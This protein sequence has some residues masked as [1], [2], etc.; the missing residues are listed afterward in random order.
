M[1]VG[2]GVGEAGCSPPSHSLISDY[3]EPRRR[4]TALSIYAFG[5]P[6]GAMIGSVAGGWLAKTYGWRVAFMAVGRPGVIL[7]L[8]VKLLVK[9]PP[10]GHSDPVERPLVVADVA[11]HAVRAPILAGCGP[12]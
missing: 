7:A 12:R 2:V 3:F 8:L 11:P 5:I 10:R 4:A 9:E 6:L 1:R